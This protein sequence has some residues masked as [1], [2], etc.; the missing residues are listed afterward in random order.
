M[1]LT[2]QFVN[3]QQ[4]NHGLVS[5]SPLVHEKKSPEKKAIWKG[6]PKDITLYQQTN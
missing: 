4:S 3:T 2:P 1:N 5:N 6:Y